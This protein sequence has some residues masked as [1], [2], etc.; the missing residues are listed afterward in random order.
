[1]GFAHRRS[2][3][4]RGADGGCGLQQ[5]RIQLRDGTPR[6]RGVPAARAVRRLNR[7]LELKSAESAP[8]MRTPKQG[9]AGCDGV[10]VPKCRAL[11]RERDEAIVFIVSG[12]STRLAE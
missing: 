12:S 1:M 10:A 3:S 9:L 11:L 4:D 7:C 6:W 2:V 8:S 5:A